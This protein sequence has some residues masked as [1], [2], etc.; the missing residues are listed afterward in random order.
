MPYQFQKDLEQRKLIR[1]NTRIS[2]TVGLAAIISVVIYSA[3]AFFF[4]FAPSGVVKD[5]KTL[6]NI[7]MIVNIVVVLILVAILALRKTLYYSNRVIDPQDT[8]K[9]I[10]VKWQKLDLILIAS[11]EVIPLAGL[12]LRVMGLP[13]DQVYHFFAGAIILFLLLMPFGIKV[14]SKL[15]VLKTSHPEIAL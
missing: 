4:T 10:L 9:E 5:P 1:E 15:Q 6:D 2:I 3:L 8:L 13:F 12:V 11:A 7:W 14:R